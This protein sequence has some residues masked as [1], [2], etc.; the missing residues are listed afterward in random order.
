MSTAS[1]IDYPPD[2]PRV[3]GDVPKDAEPVVE[4][5][6]ARTQPPDEIVAPDDGDRLVDGVRADAIPIEVDDRDPKNGQV[7]V[8]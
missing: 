7:V 5:L 4:V 6:P 3:T 2:L 8:D 1:E